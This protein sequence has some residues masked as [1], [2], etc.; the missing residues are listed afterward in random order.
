MLPSEDEAERLEVWSWW[1]RGRLAP[2][3]TKFFIQKPCR[4][5]R[6]IYGFRFDGYEILAVYRDLAEN[7]LDETLPLF[8]TN[9]R[10]KPEELA[11]T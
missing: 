8:V 5:Q 4:E 3:I 7:F 1:R 9:P 6:R 10:V 2:A 11:S